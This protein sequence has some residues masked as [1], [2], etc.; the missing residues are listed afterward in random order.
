M[1]SSFL[2]LFFSS[3]FGV[4]VPKQHLSFHCWAAD[5]LLM[6]DSEMVVIYPDCTWRLLSEIKILTE[7]EFMA[8]LHWDR[9]PELQCKEHKLTW[10]RLWRVFQHPWEVRGMVR[11]SLRLQLGHAMEAKCLLGIWMSRWKILSVWLHCT[12]EAWVKHLNWKFVLSY[13]HTL[14]FFRH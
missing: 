4:T 13:Y 3:L 11:T 8:Y 6:K 10:P 7:S 9:V 5:Y 14:S 12:E 1:K 2:F